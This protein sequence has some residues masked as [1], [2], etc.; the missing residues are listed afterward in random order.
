MFPQCLQYL[1]MD[2]CRTFV[3]GASWD[4]D[5]LITLIRFWAQRVKGQGHIIVDVA[6]ASST[7]CCHQVSF[8]ITGWVASC[9]PT[10]SNKA[11]TDVFCTLSVFDYNEL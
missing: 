1:L 11:L 10:N 9:H 2:F 6:Q 5:K 8:L 7:G 4:R 3:I